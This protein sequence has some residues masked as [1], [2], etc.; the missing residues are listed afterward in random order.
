MLELL[1][2]T[3]RGF[4]FVNGTIGSGKS[5]FANQ[6]ADG[7]LRKPASYSSNK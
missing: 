2:T 1:K 3:D 6:T 4:A 7:V 5:Y